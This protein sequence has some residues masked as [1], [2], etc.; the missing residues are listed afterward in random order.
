[1]TFTWNY[2]MYYVLQVSDGQ[3]FFSLLSLEKE[4][5]DEGF[6]AVVHLGGIYRKVLA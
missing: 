5:H 1:M 3:L 2:L 6:V 4:D